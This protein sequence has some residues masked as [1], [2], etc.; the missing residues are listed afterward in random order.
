MNLVRP[1][2][3]DSE[4]PPKNA[5]GCDTVDFCDANAE[6]VFEYSDDGLKY[7][8]QCL[9][10]YHGDGRKCEQVTLEL[11]LKKLRGLLESG[12]ECRVKHLFSRRNLTLNFFLGCKTN[13]LFYC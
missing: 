13:L 1:V 9:P 11:L 2:V 5:S 10:G 3:L 8:C 7:V 6:C 4:K 12:S